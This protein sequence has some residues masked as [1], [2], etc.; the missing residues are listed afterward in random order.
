MRNGKAATS[1]PG[2]PTVCA[3]STLGS[4]SNEEDRILTLLSAFKPQVI[5]FDRKRKVAG[6]F[7]VFKTLWRSR[8]G[9]A[10]MEGSG[11]A[12]GVAL[13]LARLLAGV[14]YV[15]SSGDA[16]GPWVARQAWWAGPFFHLYER[17][18]CRWAAGFIGWTP[19]LV[20]RAMTFGTPRAMTAPGFAPF[21]AS[22]QELQASRN[23]IRQRLGI[24][25]DSLVFGLVGS[26]AWNR[27]VKYC[28]G[29]ELVLARLR[30]QRPEI[31]IL[32]VG[33]GEGIKHLRKLA[34]QRLDK[35]IFLPGRVA[36]D[37]VPG[38]LAAMDVL[39]L[40]Q[41]TDPSGSFRY[42][43]KLSEY[44]AAGRPV[45][46]GQ[47]PMAYDLDDS[48]LWRLPGESPWDPQYVAALAR[49]MDSLSHQELQEK[50]EHVPATLHEFNRENQVRR[51][52]GFVTDIL[53]RENRVHP[54]EFEGLRSGAAQD[55]PELAFVSAGCRNGAE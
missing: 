42:T 16:I 34:G 24:P 9:L 52:T 13:M 11:L 23:G 1:S 26:L 48:W 3:F 17:C 39:S 14:P 53:Q 32:I 7:R 43:T 19:Y 50:T 20:G 4:G 18:L 41:S 25:D 29:L 31:K 36:Q 12:G 51:A 54:Y 45:V 22:P 28:Y 49:L 30:I 38:Y 47:I 5:P 46:T 2:R 40:P 35:D 21:P 27:R 15:V 10:V 44:L 55:P 6:F 33:D 8:P 37:Q